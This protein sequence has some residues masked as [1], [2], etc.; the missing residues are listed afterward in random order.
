[1]TALHDVQEAWRLLHAIVPSLYE[2][3]IM[4][5][6]GNLQSGQ[7]IQAE[8]AREEVTVGIRFEVA[9]KG[10]IRFHDQRIQNMSPRSEI[11]ARYINADTRI[12]PFACYIREE[13]RPYQEL[14]LITFRLRLDIPIEDLSGNEGGVAGGDNGRGL[15]LPAIEYPA[16]VIDMSQ[17][18]IQGGRNSP[19]EGMEPGPDSEESCV[20]DSGEDEEGSDAHKLIQVAQ[21]NHKA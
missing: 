2:R 11:H 6:R 9:N 18:K 12:S 20:T 14:D 1:M 3:S 4:N 5:Y 15:I 19:V 21:A 16:P 7:T 10:W 17:G 8:A 13:T